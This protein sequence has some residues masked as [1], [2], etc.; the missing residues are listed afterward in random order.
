MLTD[1][2]RL[3]EMTQSRLVLKLYA[4]I[5]FITLFSFAAFAQPPTAKPEEWRDDLRFLSAELIRLHPGVFSHITPAQF[6]AEVDAINTAIPSLQ[7]HIIIARL[8]KFVAMIGDSHTFLSFS[9]GSAP[10]RRYPIDWQIFSDG[11]FVTGVTSES[12]LGER[13][14]SNYA[15]T[16][17][18]KV[19]RI[20]CVDIFEAGV[21]VS[22]FVSFENEA[23]LKARIPLFLYTPEILQAAG[24]L[25]DMEHCRFRFED[26]NGNQF[27]MEFAP[28]A[29][30]L[31]IN[32]LREAR[33]QRIPTPLYRTHPASDFYWHEYLPELSTI[34]FQYNR[35]SN[36]QSLPF[37]SYLPQLL[38]AMDSN[39]VAKVVVDLRRNSGGNSAIIQP[40]INAIRARPVL[41]QRDRLFVLIDKG[42][43]SSGMLNAIDFSRLTNATFY[44]EPTGGK[45]NHYGEVRLFTL[46]HSGIA[47]QSSTRLFQIVPGDPESFF[48]NV[49]V[50]LSSADY[51]SGRDPVME[52]ILG[53]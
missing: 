50:E 5:V 49:R 34:Y 46:P 8:V 16:V 26:V 12:R 45:P 31:P 2:V 41:N 30:G 48:P 28:I 37:E 13:A 25:A 38:S 24:V 18:T 39:P 17:G 32:W 20:G 36:M 23:W 51:F 11:L 53:S 1:M 9:S 35:C 19:I 33:P 44:G 14:M 6:Q 42:T 3:T 10:F 52:K 21:A 47:V 15:R 40:F 7:D 4:Q 43:I 22:K 29:Q 27:E